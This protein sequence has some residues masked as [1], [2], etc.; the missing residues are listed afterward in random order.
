MQ[1]LNRT[2]IDVKTHT[3]VIHKQHNRVVSHLRER[4]FTIPTKLPF[5]DDI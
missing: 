2:V 5:Q 1:V 3:N 4:N